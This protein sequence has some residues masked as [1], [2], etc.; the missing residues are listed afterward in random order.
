MKLQKS[1]E[2]HTMHVS[3]ATLAAAEVTETF[4]S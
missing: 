4:G 2:I 1:E 3:E